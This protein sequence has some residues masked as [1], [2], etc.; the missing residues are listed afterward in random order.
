[1]KKILAFLIALS[2][3]S[4]SVLA[5]TKVENVELKIKPRKVELILPEF[6]EKQLGP[7]VEIDKFVREKISPRHDVEYFFLNPKGIV[8][9]QGRAESFDGSSLVVN[10][11]GFKMVW[12][13]AT[14]TKLLSAKMPRLLATINPTEITTTSIVVGTMVKVHGHWD[15]LRLIAKRI[16]SLAPRQPVKPTDFQE[17]LKK[18]QERLR[19]R[20]INVQ[21][22]TVTPTT[23]A[24]QT[25]ATTQ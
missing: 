14:D 13:I 10:S 23:S 22:A 3:V 19:E 8:S 5:Q 18:M 1:M 24:T 11:Q 20:G 9:Q 4:F 17:V 21:L 16:I 15:G 6:S 7:F 25:P 12:V 2:I